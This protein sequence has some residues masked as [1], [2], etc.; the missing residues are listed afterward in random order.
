MNRED[1]ALFFTYTQGLN[2]DFSG[3]CPGVFSK[4]ADGIYSLKMAEGGTLY[5]NKRTFQACHCVIENPLRTE[6][7][8]EGKSELTIQLQSSDNSAIYIMIG[9]DRSKASSLIENG[10]QLYPGNPLRF[11]FQDNFIVLMMKR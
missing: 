4:E 6:Y 5:P 9:S 10:D 7:Y 8:I 3:A 1:V 11:D 2:N